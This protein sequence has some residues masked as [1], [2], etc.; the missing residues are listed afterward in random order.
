MAVW[1]ALTGPH[2]MPQLATKLF[3][4]TPSCLCTDASPD[5]SSYHDYS[6]QPVGACLSR[7]LLSALPLHVC[8]GLRWH[9]L[10]GLLAMSSVLIPFHEAGASCEPAAPSCSW[11]LT[12]RVHAHA[13]QWAKAFRVNPS[14]CD[15][16]NNCPL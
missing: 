16:T 3:H 6:K 12:L 4:G 10:Q 15:I 2:A 14:F 9:V 7:S 8:V 11:L 13:P 5:T 1:L